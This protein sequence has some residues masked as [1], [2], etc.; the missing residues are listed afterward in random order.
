VSV[1]TRSRNKLSENNATRDRLVTALVRASEMTYLYCVEWGV[2][3]YSLTCHADRHTRLAY[4][5]PVCN[6]AVSACVS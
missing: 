5:G 3:L 6:S 2:K 4:P 1:A